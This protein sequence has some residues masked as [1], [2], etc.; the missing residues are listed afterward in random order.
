MSEIFELIDTRYRIDSRSL[1]L[2]REEL[3]LNMSQFAYACG[4][5]CSY[6]WQLENDRVD[7]VSEATRNVVCDVI[8][9]VRRENHES[10]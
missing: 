4:W 8:K 3:G 6:Q 7:S 9:N 10:S 5:T 1:Q 2:K